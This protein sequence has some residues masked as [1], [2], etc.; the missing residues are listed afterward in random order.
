MTALDGR[1]LSAVALSLLLGTTWPSALDAQEEPAGLEVRGLPVVNFDADEGFGFADLLLL[2]TSVHMVLSAFVDQGRVWDG[3]V[4]LDEL[5]TDLHRGFGGGIR[6]GMGEN[7]IVAFDM[8]RSAEAGT[9][10]YIG[11]GYLY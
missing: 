10:L 9:P 7:F 1:C 4:Q 5:L 2:G 8:G 3:D 6:F 11:L